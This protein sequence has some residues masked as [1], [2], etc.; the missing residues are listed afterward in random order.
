MKKKTNEYIEKKENLKENNDDENKNIDLTNN[1]NNNLFSMYDKLT[2]SNFVKGYNEEFENIN[3]ENNDFVK[4]AQELLNNFWK[5][6][7]LSYANTSLSMLLIILFY[8]WH[9]FLI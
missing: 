8:L 4:K 1:T 3:S 7:N 2:N 5:Q 9:K 6:C